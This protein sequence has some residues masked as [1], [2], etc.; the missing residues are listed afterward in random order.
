VKKFIATH[1]IMEGH[2][3]VTTSTAAQ[4]ARQRSSAPDS[5][6][7]AGSA[8]QVVSGKYHSAVV[9]KNLGMDINQFNAMNPGFDRQVRV[10][11]YT[12]RLPA[13][14]MDQFIAMRQQILGESV[15][16]ILENSEANKE[17]YPESIKLPKGKNKKETDK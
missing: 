16:F 4:L 6:R 3:G 1:Y 8:A 11:D 2:G 5:A 10:G 17:E 7:I 13:D 12:L 14:K 9:T 15:M